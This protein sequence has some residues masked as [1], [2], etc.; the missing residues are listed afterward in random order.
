M[1]AC[2]AKCYQLKANSFNYFI[3]FTELVVPSV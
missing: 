3:T 1:A 2:V